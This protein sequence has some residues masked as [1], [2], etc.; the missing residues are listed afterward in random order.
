MRRQHPAALAAACLLAAVPASR[1]ELDV[2]DDYYAGFAQG[3]YYGMLLAGEDYEVAWCMRG[4]LEVE[5]R[6]MGRGEE[7]QHTLERLL[8]GCRA[9]QAGKPGPN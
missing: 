2:H 1:A 8:K 3:A 9:E 4:E 5:A 7:F 6:G